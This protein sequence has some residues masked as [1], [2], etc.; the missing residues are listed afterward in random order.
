MQ[1]RIFF[2]VFEAQID[3]IVRF[4]STR[5]P[6][7]DIFPPRVFLHLGISNERRRRVS[8]VSN[9]RSTRTFRERSLSPLGLPSAVLLP[10]PSPAPQQ[11]RRALAPRPTASSK[12]PGSAR[13]AC[14]SPDG[15]HST[16]IA[17]A[18]GAPTEG[19]HVP[20]TE[21]R[22]R[23]LFNRNLAKSSTKNGANGFV[24]PFFANPGTRQVYNSRKL[25]S[26][27]EEQ[28]VAQPTFFFPNSC[29]REIWPQSLEFPAHNAYFFACCYNSSRALIHR[30]FN[31][32]S[33]Q[34]H[35]V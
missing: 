22:R 28:Q 6:N 27:S 35:V 11:R 23:T 3:F 8:R 19:R 17:P 4:P 33:V 16:S 32:A 21:Q 25:A 30:R 24:L 1:P 31:T 9:E 20:P 5:S 34:S 29:A 18:R 26:G 2:V 15:R 7:V 10:R 13:V 14:F 12:P